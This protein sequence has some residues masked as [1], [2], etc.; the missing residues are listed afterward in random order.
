L[1]WAEAA[2]SLPFIGK[3]EFA[4]LLTKANVLEALGK[5]AEAETIMA[6]A[7]KLP[8]ASVMDIHQYGRSLQAVGKKEKA[9]EVFKLNRQMHP[10]DKFTT[11]VGLARGYTSMDDKKNAIKNWEIAIKNIPEDQ[12]RNLTFYEGELKKLKG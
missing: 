5:N 11:Y 12:K 2:I 8:S 7:I 6:K 9:F 4:T 3:E 10:D 1:T